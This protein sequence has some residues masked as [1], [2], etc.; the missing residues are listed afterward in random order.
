MTLTINSNFDSGN[1]EILSI[2]GDTATLAIRKDEASNFY[3]WFHFRVAGAE[4]RP[5]T[6]RITNCAGSAYPLGWPGYRAR[7]SNDR[8]DWQQADTSYADGVLTI[9]HTPAQGAVWFAYH[10]PYSIE[11]HHDLVARIGAAA[12]VRVAEL[13]K[14]LDGQPI[15]CLSIGTGMKSVWLYARQHPG[16]SMAE[17]WA[18]GALDL[19]VS[20]DPVAVKLRAAATLPSRS[21]PCER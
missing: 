7:F 6:V 13:G 12:P 4:G 11:R 14:T 18:E 20:D 17:W 16:E 1:I 9:R 3:Q 8:L 10:A 15:D 19:L 2:D 5:V 21:S